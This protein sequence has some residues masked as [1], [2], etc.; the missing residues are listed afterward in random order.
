MPGL[1]Q[2]GTGWDS[3]ARAS[4]ANRLLRLQH[5]DPVWWAIAAASLNQVSRSKKIKT[6]TW[7]FEFLMFQ[8]LNNERRVIH[9][10]S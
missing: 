6:R 7:K 3:R 10:P 4:L 2:A 1:G 9:A 8:M 5:R